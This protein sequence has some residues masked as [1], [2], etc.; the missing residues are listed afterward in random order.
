MVSTLQCNNVFESDLV[1]RIIV[2]RSKVFGCR[3]DTRILSTSR[4]CVVTRTISLLYSLG[5]LQSLNIRLSGSQ[6]RPGRWGEWK[7]FYSSM[8]SNPDYLPGT[9][10]NPNLPTLTLLLRLVTILYWK[11]LQYILTYDKTQFT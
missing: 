2:S 7:H 9:S 8:Q 5:I 4:R 1:V 11:F 6:N 10:N 3:I